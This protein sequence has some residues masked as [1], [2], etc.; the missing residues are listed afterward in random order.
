[1]TYFS[2][3]EREPPLPTRTELTTN[4]W[5]G[6]SAL[7]RTRVDDGS[8]GASYPEMCFD[9]SIPVG[10]NSEAF[11]DAMAGRIPELPERH[12]IVTPSDPPPIL[13]VMDMIQFCWKSV[14]KPEQFSYH[15]FGSHSHLKYNIDLGKEEF[16]QEI[17]EIF[18]RSELAFE[19][20]VEGNIER[21]LP[22]EV[23][24]IVHT[25]YRTTDDDLNEMLT[26]SCRNILSPNDSVRREA[27]KTLWDAWER[28]KTINCANKKAAISELVDQISGSGVPRFRRSLHAEARALTDI[29]NGFQIRHSETNQE[30]LSIVEHIDY[31]WYRM[32]AFMHLILRMIGSVDEAQ[33]SDSADAEKDEE[34]PF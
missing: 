30:R 4:A 24:K 9:G 14:G 15:D 12:V 32:F 22:P 34:I 7:I 2:D 18:Q 28:L 10:T 33:E 16:R 27:L 26:T 3:R 23:A 21:V 13:V 29:G 1:M 31:L 19:L 20:T 6:I 5:K 17:N 25:R 8:F 11:W